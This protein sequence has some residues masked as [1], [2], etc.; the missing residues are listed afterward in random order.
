MNI[1]HPKFHN[2]LQIGLSFSRNIKRCLQMTLDGLAIFISITSAM[3][4]RLET[5]NF[6]VKLNY[7]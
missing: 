7:F 2:I 1:K 4:L 5:F 3:A 6:L